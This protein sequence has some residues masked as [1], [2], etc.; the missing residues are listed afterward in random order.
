[1]SGGEAGGAQLPMAQE[2]SADVAR[3][4]GTAQPLTFTNMAA[5][6]D[7]GAPQRATP[8]R[9]AARPPGALRQWAPSGAGRAHRP[10]LAPR[11]RRP[12]RR[13]WPMRHAHLQDARGSTHHP[14]RV[15]HSTFS[16]RICAAAHSKHGGPTGQGQRIF[17]TLRSRFPM[18]KERARLPTSR[19][20]EKGASLP[21]ESASDRSSPSP[22]SR[23]AA[24]G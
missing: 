6:G 19:V 2:R 9:P 14:G 10:P 4:R 24:N 7:R 18:G 1:M 23:P 3:P 8:V 21:P 13:E 16:R 17:E 11:R 15:A 12:D 20:T 5:K 22:A